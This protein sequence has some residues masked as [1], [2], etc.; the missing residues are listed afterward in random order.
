[1]AGFILGGGYGALIGRFGVALDNLLGATV[2]LADGRV[3]VANCDNEEELF[4]ALRGG[5]GNFGVV[6]AMRHH[7]HILPSV[8]SGML[9]YPF[10]EA[11]AVLGR[12]A[13]IAASAP[14][15]LTFQVGCV[16]GPDRKP[17]V[18][19]V[20]T[21]CGPPE[22]GEAQV[23]P[24]LKL[25]TLLSGTMDATCYGAS[26]TLFDPYIFNGQRVFMETCWLPALDSASIDVFI[27]TMETGV[28]PGCAIFT[29]EFK[30]ARR[31][32][33]RRRRLLACAATMCSSRSSLCS[34]PTGVR[35]NRIASGRVPLFRPSIR[36]R[37]PARIRTSSPKATWT[38][39]RKAMV[40]TRNGSPEPSAI[41]IPTTSS[42]PPFHCQSVGTN[43]DPSRLA[44]Q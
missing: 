42:I 20:P 17:V 36:L 37:F 1:M 30:G 24:F 8:R 44:D 25:G 21:W 23:A 15:E 12:C 14:E 5:G 2:V 18:M 32:Y 41:T 27:Q 4:W 33:P 19:I 43:L 31:E 10:S 3:L 6:A 40:A 22:Q 26:L 7:L 11:R 39:S 35:S 16:G 9:I 28:S 13:N 38:V 34:G 29:H